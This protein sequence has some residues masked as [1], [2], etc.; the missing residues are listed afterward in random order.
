MIGLNQAIW[1]INVAIKSIQSLAIQLKSGAKNVKKI[2]SIA[3]RNKEDFLNE[4]ETNLYNAALKVLIKTLNRG[5]EKAAEIKQNL[6]TLASDL[7][8]IEETLSSVSTRLVEAANGEGE[9]F[10]E[11]ATSLREKVYG[12]CAASVLLGPGAVA[13][14][15]GIGAAVI[16]TD[17]ADRKEEIAEFK[18]EFMSWSETFALLANM[19]GQAKEVSQKWYFKIESFS[20]DLGEQ[21]DLI[22]ALDESEIL[23]YDLEMRNMV[24]DSLDKLIAKC[25]EVINDTTGR[26]EDVTQ[27]MSAVVPGYKQ[28]EPK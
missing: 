8:Q 12:G 26:L 23:P 10:D 24:D 20:V 18:A 4:R 19:A 25:D 11:W 21:V 3:F 27:D 22:S 7:I 9:A 14:C 28:E 6:K 1:D 17:I 13:A 5:I 2:A 15:Y 16:E